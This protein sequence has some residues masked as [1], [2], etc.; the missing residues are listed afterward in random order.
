MSMW[1]LFNNIGFEWFYQGIENQIYI[2]I[3]FITVRLVVI[4]FMF[5]FIKQPKDYIKYAMIIVF[6]NSGSNFFNLINIKKYISLKNIKIRDINILKHVKPILTISI[7]FIA[8]SIYSQ[9]DIIMLGLLDKKAVAYYTVSNNLVKSLL[10]LITALGLVLLP[11]ISNCIKIKDIKNY[12][13]YINYS[14]KYILMVSVPS[15]LGTLL[16]ADNIILIIAGE[17]FIHSILVLKILIFTV[18][19][20]GIAF[21]L[22]FQILYPHG[23]EKYYTFSVIVSAIINFI[24]NYI[25]IPR[26]YQNG[27]A[28]GTVIAEILNVIMMLYFT[29]N[30]L[31]DIEFYSLK[32]LKYFISTGIMGIIILF[33]KSFN[34]GNLITLLISISFGSIIYFIILF[35]LKEDIVI[36]GFNI[37]KN[38]LIGEK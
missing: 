1:I 16:L 18:F 35:L 2:T 25:M 17:E 12:E 9:L 21:F 26:Y 3:R 7:A 31:R 32:N 30:Y 33:I 11:R 8:T 34:L 37:L 28:F 20:I 4:F 22:G 23:Q 27:A 24:F 13:K 15:L 36:L 14:L 19:F 10:V 6:M 38:K 5:I 29:R